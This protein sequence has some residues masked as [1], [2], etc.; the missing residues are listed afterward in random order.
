M[1]PRLAAIL[2]PPVARIDAAPSGGGKVSSGLAGL[3][4]HA[5][6]MRGAPPGYI[7]RPAVS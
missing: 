7:N 6:A 2:R 5:G 1:T 3:P 4:S